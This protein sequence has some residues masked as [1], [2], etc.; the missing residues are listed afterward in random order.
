MVLNFYFLGTI[1]AVYCGN[2]NLIVELFRWFLKLLPG[3][4]N[5]LRLKF[6]E[7][8]E[9]VNIFQ[10]FIFVFLFCHPLAQYLITAC[11]L[12]FMSVVY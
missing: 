8:T 4:N 2:K 5:S 7:N 9:T 10:V 6:S 11:H 3:I 12:M 1:N